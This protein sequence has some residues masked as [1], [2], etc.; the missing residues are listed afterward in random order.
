MFNIQ[1]LTPALLDTL[2]LPLLLPP[3]W[4]GAVEVEWRPP[5]PGQQQ[6]PTQQQQHQRQPPL[7]PSSPDTPAGPD[8]TAAQGDQQQQ[9]QPSAEWVRLLWRWLG[10][11][12]RQEV[13][14]LRSWPVLPI[15][16]GRL[17]RLEETSLV[18]HTAL[19][20]AALSSSVSPSCN[21]LISRKDFTIC[22]R[23]F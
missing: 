7:Q 17:G 13:L 22:C 9:Q 8:V 6:T 23:C 11:R 3:Q 19:A 16:G 2:L 15:Q 1:N 4:L 21:F 12:P 20:A 14:A 5:S 10:S 18:G